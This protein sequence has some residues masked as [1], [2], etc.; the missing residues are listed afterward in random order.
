VSVLQ[1][2]LQHRL[3]HDVG[4]AAALRRQR[5]QDG[6][7]LST[8][9]S[10]AELHFA[11]HKATKSQHFAGHQATKSQHFAGHKAT[12]LQHSMAD[13]TAVAALDGTGVGNQSAS[14][15]PA[16]HDGT[17]VLLYD[18]AAREV[19]LH[20]II[21]VAGILDPLRH[22]DDCGEESDFDDPDNAIAQ[23]SADENVESGGTDEPHHKVGSCPA[24][25]AL[26]SHTAR[27]WCDA[28]ACNKILQNH[29]A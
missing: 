12:K 6:G 18:A 26:P 17:I 20:D 9:I 28:V 15:M 13:P 3:C 1:F 7:Y 21:D 10:Q 22:E 14:A 24:S 25:C 19:K 16:L 5:N 23:D 8:A 11:G 27:S 2:N 29:L 4:H